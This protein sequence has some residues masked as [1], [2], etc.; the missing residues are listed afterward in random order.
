MRGT[1]CHY[2][3]GLANRKETTM[4]VDV[5]IWFKT[6]DGQEPALERSLPHGYSIVAA[7]VNACLHG[8]THEIDTYA[9]FYGKGYERG[10]WPAI[11]AVLML[12]HACETVEKVW[13]DGDTCESPRECPPER[14]IEISWHYMQYGERPYNGRMI[15]G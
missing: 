10:P 8:A 3:R 5:R 9:R 13:Y 15:R 4:G 7:D 12:L 11:C 6:K 1:A 2:D 14:V